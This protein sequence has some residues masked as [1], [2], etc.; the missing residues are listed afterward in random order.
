VSLSL[1]IL[2][3]ERRMKKLIYPFLL[4]LLCTQFVKAEW[5]DEK[6]VR[7]TKEIQ[8][9]LQNWNIEDTIQLINDTKGKN[10]SNIMKFRG[11]EPVKFQ[12]MGETILLNGR[13]V[14]GTLGKKETHG[15]YSP[16][17][18]NVEDSKIAIGPKAKIIEESKNTKI[19]KITHS[20]NTSIIEN[21]K[22]SNIAAGTQNKISEESKNTN[23]NINFTL[24]IALTF[25]LLINIYLIFRSRKRKNKNS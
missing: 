22:D 3:K 4:I 16:I 23:I 13:D 7:V 20:D 15:D 2:K 24:S 10:T 19:D 5:N 9:T 6:I 12:V 25:S 14:S 8:K 17:I 21:V 11:G 18:E 1:A